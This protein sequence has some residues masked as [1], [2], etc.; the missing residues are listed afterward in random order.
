LFEDRQVADYE[1]IVT[2]DHQTARED[3]ADT[4]TLVEACEQYVLKHGIE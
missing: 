4:R 1:W 2:V 3:V